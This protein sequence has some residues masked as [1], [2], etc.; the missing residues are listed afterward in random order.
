MNQGKDTNPTHSDY[1]E[2]IRHHES[3]F[4]EY[5]KAFK[6]NVNLRAK[7]LQYQSIIQK[8]KNKIIYLESQQFV[9]D[10]E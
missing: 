1:I 6:T 2:L 4:K 5:M 3:L 7:Q 8:Q 9:N 10:D